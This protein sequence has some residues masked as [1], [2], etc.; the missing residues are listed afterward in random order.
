VR[1]LEPSN[2]LVNFTEDDFGGDLLSSIQCDPAGRQ[3]ELPG[4]EAL[5]S[6]RTRPGD[7]FHVRVAPT[8]V[9]GDTLGDDVRL[10]G[11]QGCDAGQCFRQADRCGEGLPETL[12]FRVGEDTSAGPRVFGVNAGG[13]SRLAIRVARPICGNAAVDPGETCDDGDGL[14]P[15]GCDGQCRAVLS[16]D[17][18]EVQEVEPNDD[19]TQANFVQLSGEGFTAIAGQLTGACDND[20]YAVRVPQGTTLSAV[21]LGVRGS[22]CDAFGSS[23]QIEFED[24]RNDVRIEGQPPENP[25]NPNTCEA[26]GGV[27]EMRDLPAG[28]Y[29]FVV[30]TPKDLGGQLFVYQLRI[31]QK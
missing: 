11:L 17:D 28:E 3:L 18:D 22:P 14:E 12:G 9:G 2:A 25:E 21:I 5:F 4:P 6:V 27:A 1:A 30:R 15:G 19:R 8:A 26:V 16:P 31:A 10:F 29:Q 23:A 24:P 7:R 13:R 20:R